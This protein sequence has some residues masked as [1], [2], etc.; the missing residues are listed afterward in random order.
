M[1]AG[2]RGVAVEM[3][4]LDAMLAAQRRIHLLKI[5]VEG[6]EKMVLEGARRPGADGYGLLRVVRQE[7]RPVRLRLRGRVAILSARGFSTFRFAGQRRLAAVSADYESEIC[8]NLVSVRSPGD[9]LARTG[10]DVEESRLRARREPSSSV[11][12]SGRRIGDKTNPGQPRGPPVRASAAH[13]H[14]RLLSG[15]AWIVVVSGFSQGSAFLASIISARLLGSRQFGELA[16]IQC[17]LVT[18]GS[19]AGMGLGVT[20]TKMVAELRHRNPVRV[21]RVLGLCAVVAACRESSTWPACSSPRGGL[22][23][24][25]SRRSSSPR[26]CKSARRTCCCRRSTRFKSAP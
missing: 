26:N 4:T 13:A 7:F 18:A 15:V 3:S 25:C 16:T 10:F 5:D 21:G 2:D 6:Y 1:V 9:F 8:E 12:D 17:V 19:F 11:V 24:T 14:A 22:R 20:A 23:E